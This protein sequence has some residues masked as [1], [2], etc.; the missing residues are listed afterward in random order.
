[1]PQAA[2]A[3]IFS[4]PGPRAPWGA[5]FVLHM[6]ARGAQEFESTHVL[7]CCGRRMH[8]WPSPQGEFSG[9]P[10]AF[11]PGAALGDDSD[12]PSSG[13]PGR[14]SRLNGSEEKESLGD[15]ESRDVGE[16]SIVLGCRF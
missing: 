15:P 1:M 3:P 5:A 2:I 14:E 13:D 10:H 16:I 12:G 11:A 7:L 4:L 9:R 8:I 6:P